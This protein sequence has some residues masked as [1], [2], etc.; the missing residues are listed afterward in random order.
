MPLC[1]SYLVVA[2]DKRWCPDGGIS[3]R[4][5]GA[6]LGRAVALISL[7]QGHEQV[8]PGKAGSG[9]VVSS[10]RKEGSRIWSSTPGWRRGHG[11][12]VHEISWQKRNRSSVECSRAPQTTRDRQDRVTC[13]ST[14]GE[15]QALSPLPSRG[16]RTAGAVERPGTPIDPDRPAGLRPTLPDDRKEVPGGLNLLNDL[17]DVYDQRPAACLKSGEEGVGVSTDPHKNPTI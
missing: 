15:G 13:P 8:S 12:P 1:R 4:A 9:V 7:L 17:P 11:S 2:T 5:D 14:C 10:R 3:A 6:R 16:D